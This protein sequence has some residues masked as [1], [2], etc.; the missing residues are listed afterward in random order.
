[1]DALGWR[2]SRVRTLPPRGKVPWHEPPRD[3]QAEKGAAH[4]W[5]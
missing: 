4:D 3:A 1:M 2:Y 5:L